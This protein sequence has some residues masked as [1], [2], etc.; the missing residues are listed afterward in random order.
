VKTNAKLPRATFEITQTEV[1]SYGPGYRW[2]AS[3]RFTPRRFAN[4]L[5]LVSTKTILPDGDLIAWK[6]LRDGTICKLKIPAEAK[7]VGGLIGRKCRADFAV[8]IFGEGRDIHTGNTKYKIGEKVVPDSFDP[9]PL[10]ECSHGIHFYITEQEAKD[11][12]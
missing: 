11:H 8:V 9:N 2:S 7:R 5:R 10:I 3:R 6:K 12:S 1:G 4:L